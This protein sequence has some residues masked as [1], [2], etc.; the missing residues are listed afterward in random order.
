MVGALVAAAACGAPAARPPAAN[1]TPAP[2][3]DAVRAYSVCFAPPSED[4]TRRFS[5]HAVAIGGGVDLHLGAVA[6]DGRTAY[7]LVRRSAADQAVAA[8]DLATGAVTS[9]AALPAGAAGIGSM[10]AS[11]SWVVWQQAN[12]A[13]NLGDW[14]VR[15]WSRESG[16][17]LDLATSR[18]PDGQQAFGQAPLP[19]AGRGMVAWAQP[20]P[21]QASHPVATVERYDLA[22]RR[23]TVLDSGRVSGPVLA[24]A[25]LV[26][27]RVEADGSYA[28]RAVDA[29]SLRAAPLPERVRAPGPVVYL[30][31][32]DRYLAWSTDQRELHVWRLGTREYG[33]YT[34]DVRHPLQF[35]RLAGDFTL[36]YAGLPSTVLDL[37]TGHAFDVRGSLAGTDGLIAESEAA[38]LSY[39]PLTADARI[40]GCG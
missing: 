5:E 39:A 16:E 18:S 20:Q 27:A 15:A 9:I 13:A 24:G 17:T 19:V 2:P 36:W 3:P 6:D 4:W 38:R 40:D 12:S 32:S 22:S 23:T 10:A 28:L 37:R 33:D 21:R 29:V 1:A 7:G 8:V 14:A 30:A 11:G 34:A 31:G 26:W 25:D 35:L